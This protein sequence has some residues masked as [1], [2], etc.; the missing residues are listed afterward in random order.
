MGSW[1]ALI[2]LFHC[3]NIIL[4]IYWAIFFYLHFFYLL[5]AFAWG[6]LILFNENIII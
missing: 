3:F 2:G 5:N 6:F 4:K 1:M